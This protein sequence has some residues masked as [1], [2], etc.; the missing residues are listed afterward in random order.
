MAPVMGGRLPIRAS[1]VP[2]DHMELTNQPVCF[3]N[4]HTLHTFLFSHTVALSWPLDIRCHCTLDTSTVHTD[5]GEN[6]RQYSC[7]T[8]AQSP[9]ESPTHPT[10]IASVCTS[11]S[12]RTTSLPRTNLRRAC[13]WK[14]GVGSRAGSCSDVRRHLGP[15]NCSSSCSNHLNVNELCNGHLYLGP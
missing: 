12:L 3:S 10:P 13:E 1:G 15:H 2:A 4:V 6:C 5:N 7:A 14:Q 11:T 9:W 8:W